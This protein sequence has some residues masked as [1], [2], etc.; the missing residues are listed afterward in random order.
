MSNVPDFKCKLTRTTFVFLNTCA[1]NHF[2]TQKRR[3][4]MKGH[5]PHFK[6]FP[7]VELMFN[8]TK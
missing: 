3:P 6:V 2:H 7:Y 8:G 1:G 4:S 5:V